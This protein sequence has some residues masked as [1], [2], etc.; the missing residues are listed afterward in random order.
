MAW[1]EPGGGRDNDPWGGRGG[2]KGPPD[3]DEALRK[4]QRQLANIF[5]GKGGRGTGPRGAQLAVLGA[6]VAFMLW[7]LFG[8]YVVDQAERAVVFR[9]G[10]MQPEVVLPGLHW[11]P[12]F[13]DSIEKVN[14][15][16]VNSRDLQSLMLSEDQNLVDVSLT[17]QWVI[18]DAQK[19]KTRVRDPEQSLADATESA[20]R[21][22]IGSSTMDSII[23]EGR[24]QIATSV[25]T[26]LQQYLDRY[27]A[28]ILVSKVNINQSGPPKQ[29]QA[30]FDDVQ[31]AK[32]DEVKV[33]NE[34]NAYAESVIPAARGEAQKQIE[35]SNAYHDRVIAQAEGDAERFNKLFVEYSR[36]KQV[37]RNR[38]Y[39]DAMESVLGNASKVLID[40]KGGNNMLYLPLDKLID[41][42]RANSAGTLT[43]APVPAAREGGE[44]AVPDRS[45]PTRETRP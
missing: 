10:A 28:G 19:F 29:V 39:I 7:L 23:T 43:T 1:N 22:V 15:T 34:A 2:D 33:V 40:V 31:R 12:L 8:A 36:N 32:E 18:N 5:S 25:Q 35:E 42:A 24:E 38:M 45:A 4:L 11:R 20:L 14:V 16:Q 37:T 9:F 21:H 6:G 3:L 27:G 41:Q 44:M 13:I 17:V 30:A 26:R